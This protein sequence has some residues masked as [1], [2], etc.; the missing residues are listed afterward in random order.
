MGRNRRVRET[1][2]E[3]WKEVQML[4]RQQ[5]K[6]VREQKIH[7]KKKIMKTREYDN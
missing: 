6:E 7:I 4:R 5:I 1:T 3:K 2:Q